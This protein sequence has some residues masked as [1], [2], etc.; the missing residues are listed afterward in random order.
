MVYGALKNC[1]SAVYI[2]RPISAK[3]NHFVAFESALSPC[4]SSH[5]FGGA[6]RKP[7]GGAAILD[8]AGYV[9]C[10][11]RE[12]PENTGRA[13]RVLR[14]AI[15]LIRSIFLKVSSLREN[16]W[17]SARSGLVSDLLIFSLAQRHPGTTVD[18]I[19]RSDIYDLSLIVV[20]R[21]MM[22]NEFSVLD[23]STSAKHWQ[24]LCICNLSNEAL[25]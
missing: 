4:G 2:P 17:G 21:F 5:D 1:S 24:W 6:I 22:L 16:F 19:Q 18:E 10:N 23:S 25:P 20:D 15:P 3:R 12:T 14:L 9:L 13:I 7:D 11:L 8:P